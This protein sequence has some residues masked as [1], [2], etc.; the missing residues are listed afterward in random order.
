MPVVLFILSYVTQ[1]ET[2]TVTTTNGGG[3]LHSGPTHPFNLTTA[4]VCSLASVWNITSKLKK[5]MQQN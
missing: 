1:K 4:T 5:N 3:I 2:Y